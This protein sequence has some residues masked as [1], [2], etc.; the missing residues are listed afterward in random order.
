MIRILMANE[1]ARKLRKQLTPHEAKL[2]MQLR[3]LP[4]G[5]FHFR[6]QVPI[7]P[8]IVDFAEKTHK[9][10]IELD[11]SQHQR[12]EAIERDKKRDQFLTTKGFKVLHIWNSEID[13]NM[14]GVID[15][16]LMACK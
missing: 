1:F 13:Q 10:V 15:T 11:G 16:I 9:L 3:L 5:K 12:P 6:R 4:K 7:G 14:S 8:Y 2:W